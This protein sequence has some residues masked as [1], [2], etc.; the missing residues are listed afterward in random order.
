MVCA[1]VPCV[2]NALEPF[3]T[4]ASP[5]RTAAVRMAAASLPEPGSVRPQAASFSP[6]ASGGRNLALSSSPANIEMWEAPRPLCAAT[7]S[8]TLGSTRASSSM[9]MQ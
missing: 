8:D 1:E 4:H 5:S 9:Q 6:R 2:M 3:R 7:D